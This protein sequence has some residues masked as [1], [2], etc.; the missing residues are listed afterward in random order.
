MKKNDL[1]LKDCISC[2]TKNEFDRM[3]DLFEIENTFGY[4]QWDVYEEKTVLFPFEKAY[5]EIEGYC[6]ENNYN[7]I[8]S[9]NIVSS[10]ND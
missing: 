9:T 1:K 6:V 8:A 10:E 7:V 5:G 4:L 3:L 2:K